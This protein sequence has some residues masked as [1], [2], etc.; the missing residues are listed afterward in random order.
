[1]PFGSVTIFKVI[2]VHKPILNISSMKNFS[3]KKSV[4][5]GIYR[6]TSIYLPLPS[7]KMILK[8]NRNIISSKINCAVIHNQLHWIYINLIWCYSRLANHNSSSCS[9]VFFK[10]WLIHQEI[11]HFMVKIIFFIGCYV[12]NNC[13]SLIHFH[14][15]LGTLPMHFWI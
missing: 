4:Y 14:C 2:T 3:N 11:F 13:V 9:Y 7:L 6:Y 15:I 12:G 8:R 10:L 5:I 1:M